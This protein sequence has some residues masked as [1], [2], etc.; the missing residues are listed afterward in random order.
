[1]NSVLKTVLPSLG[2]FDLVG[3]KKKFILDK[4]IFLMSSSTI[5]SNKNQ[6]FFL[7]DLI[8]EVE[9]I[10]RAVGRSFSCWC[11]WRRPKST[12][13]NVFCSFVSSICP[14]HSINIVSIENGF[15]LV[16]YHVENFL[17]STT[18][19]VQLT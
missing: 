12:D 1:M 5:I 7:L 13:A 15:N 10:H 11:T 3:S 17:V 9:M 2:L 6:M 8:Q 14:P 18:R 19:Q 4:H 16:E